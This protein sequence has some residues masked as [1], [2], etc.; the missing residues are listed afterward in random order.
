MT[1]TG[2]YDGYFKHGHEGAAAAASAAAFSGKASC[3]QSPLLT[4]TA[5]SKL[6]SALPP[7]TVLS[8]LMSV[9]VRVQW[10]CAVYRGFAVLYG[11]LQQLLSC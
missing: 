2:G 4:P 9:L 3:S 5:C 11:V 8:T 10:R 6:T 7:T 1:C